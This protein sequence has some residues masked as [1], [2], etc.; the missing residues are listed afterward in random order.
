MSCPMTKFPSGCAGNSDFSQEA[1]DE[2]PDLATREGCD[3]IN[4]EK[5]LEPRMDADKH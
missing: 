2:A 1:G 4:L 5:E 3:R